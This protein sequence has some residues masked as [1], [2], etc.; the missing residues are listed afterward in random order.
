MYTFR[1]PRITSYHSRTIA[2]IY[3]TTQSTI[4]SNH[5]TSHRKIHRVHETAELDNAFRDPLL[6]T[7]SYDTV[8]KLHSYRCSQVTYICSWSPGGRGTGAVWLCGVRRRSGIGG[9]RWAYRGTSRRDVWRYIHC[10]CSGGLRR[11]IGGAEAIWRGRW[12]STR[13]TTGVSRGGR[14]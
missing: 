4:S 13:I 2:I 6:P 11:I 7:H 9:D 12:K 3:V 10:R 1:R 5:H 8:T 14:I